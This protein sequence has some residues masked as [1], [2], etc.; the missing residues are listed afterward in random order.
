MTNR[1]IDLGAGPSGGSDIGVGSDRQFFRTIGSTGT[2]SDLDILNAIGNAAASQDID[3]ADGDT[4]SAT[5]T[6][7]TTFT[8]SSP[9]TAD[10]FALF[11]TNGGAF[12]VTWPASVDW[13]GGTAPT[14]T[15]AG[16][17]LI[18]F[19]TLDGGTIWHGQI[20]ATD[21]K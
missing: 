12:A 16:V 19:S 11:L 3:L 15:A 8:F 2:W 18:V 6:E 17:D 13:P 1:P 5:I 14:L 7:A 20:A 4:V 9:N 10:G 21:S